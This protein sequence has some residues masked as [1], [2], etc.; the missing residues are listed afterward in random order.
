MFEKIQAAWNV[1]KAG[2]VVANPAA[3]KKGQVHAN[4]ITAVL[5]ALVYLARMFE[6]PLPPIDEETLGGIAIGLFALVNWV[7]TVVS[8]D[9]VGVLG[10]VR[11]NPAPADRSEGDLRGDGPN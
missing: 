1:L 6:L 3:W 11:P 5:V 9:K 2:Q 4:Q 10:N 7:F 8:T